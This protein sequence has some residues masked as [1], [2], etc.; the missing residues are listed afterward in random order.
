MGKLFGSSS[1]F[2]VKVIIVEQFDGIGFLE[3]FGF[4][5][6]CWNSGSDGYYRCF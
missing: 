3:I 6:F 1:Y 2:I 5:F 4:E